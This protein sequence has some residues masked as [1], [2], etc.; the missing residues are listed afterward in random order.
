MAI[1]SP[2]VAKPEVHSLMQPTVFVSPAIASDLGQIV[3]HTKS[4][5]GFMGLVKRE[6]VVDDDDLMVADNYIL[7]ELMLLDQECHSAT[8]ELSPEAMAALGIELLGR[9]NGDYERLLFWGHTHPFGSTAPSGQDESQMA[10]FR[11]NGC[12]WF[13][14]GIFAP[15][16]SE[17]TLF[18]F[19]QHLV[20]RDVPWRIQY[21]VEDRS[22]FWKAQ[23][24]AKV[25]DCHNATGFFKGGKGKHG[26]QGTTQ[27]IVVRG[28]GKDAQDHEFDNFNC[29]E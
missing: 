25:K 13:L 26:S 9:N 21:P 29:G 14:R 28:S 4:E 27:A 24:E 18:N 2:H 5:V 15:Q 16:R 23:I 6:I 8:T 22:A 1:V 10:L 12:P 7:D 17:Y 3:K 19:Q 20:F 11:K